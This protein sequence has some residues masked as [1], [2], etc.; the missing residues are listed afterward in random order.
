MLAELVL[1]TTH[2]FKVAQTRKDFKVCAHAWHLLWFYAIADTCLL[3][4]VTTHSG[5]GCYRDATG[6]CKNYLVSLVWH[7]FFSWWDCWEWRQQLLN[8]THCRL[9]FQHF[10]CFEWINEHKNK[11]T[12]VVSYLVMKL[13]KIKLHKNACS[14]LLLVSQWKWRNVN[15]L[16]G[17]NWGVLRKYRVPGLLLWAIWCLLFILFGCCAVQGLC[18]LIQWTESLD[19]AGEQR[20]S[21]MMTSGLHLCFLLMTYSF[22]VF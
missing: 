2:L 19:K 3:K 4:T 7:Y 21:G 12:A 8:N 17:N 9:Y 13:G 11:C 5:Y 6:D 18:L 22:W 10:C 15:S 20:V 16:W 14:P 1:G